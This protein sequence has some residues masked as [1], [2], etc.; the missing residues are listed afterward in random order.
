[1]ESINKK[2]IE[3]YANK[4]CELQKYT[5]EELTKVF[6]LTHCRMQNRRQNSGGYIDLAK[7]FDSFQKGENKGFGKNNEEIQENIN[8]Y[9]KIEAELDKEKIDN[10]VLD[11]IFS[12]MKIDRREFK[13]FVLCP[14][15]EKKRAEPHQEWHILISFYLVNSINNKEKN[16]FEK[17]RPCRE[18]WFWLAEVTKNDILKEMPDKA[19]EFTNLAILELGNECKIANNRIKIHKQIYKQFFEKW[20]CAHAVD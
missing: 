12:R 17:N 20:D 13:K 2:I 18:L 10:D 1:M 6:P 14:G 16:L 9:K 19:N 8:I 7:T 3:Y 11:C 4:A 5:D 15:E